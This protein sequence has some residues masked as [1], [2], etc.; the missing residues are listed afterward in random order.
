MRQLPTLTTPSLLPVR[1]TFCVSHAIIC[2]KMYQ[3]LLYVNFQ[4]FNAELLYLKSYVRKAVF[5]LKLERV[6]QIH[7]CLL[8]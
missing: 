2:A 7:L 8:L 1:M 3:M 4:L 6:V 5:M